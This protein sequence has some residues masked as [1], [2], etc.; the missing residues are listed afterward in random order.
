[1]KTQQASIITLHLINYCVNYEGY[2]LCG[3]PHSHK[4]HVILRLICCDD[5]PSQPIWNRRDGGREGPSQ[6]LHAFKCEG[7][8]G[9]N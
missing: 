7:L 8:L 3:H 4:D 6:I 5:E 9:S 1:M 2:Y